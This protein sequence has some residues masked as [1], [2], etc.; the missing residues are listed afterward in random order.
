MLSL[1]SLQY[2]ITVS[3]V[4]NDFGHWC[5]LSKHKK[6]KTHSGELCHS[7]AIKMIRKYFDMSNSHSTISELGLSGRYYDN[8]YSVVSHCLAT[9]H[10]IVSDSPLYVICIILLWRKKPIHD[11]C[12]SNSTR[13]SFISGG[14]V[15]F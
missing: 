4:E 10:I 1:N 11:S 2:N 8:F 7:Y 5:I 9:G 15:Y 6:K 12:S 13:R 14:S 3:R